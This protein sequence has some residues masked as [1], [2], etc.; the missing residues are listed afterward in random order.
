MPRLQYKLTPE[1]RAIVVDYIDRKFASDLAA[2]PEQRW[3][4]NVQA[5][6][7]FKQAKRNVGTLDAWC[8]LWLDVKQRRRLK[9]SLRQAKKRKAANTG[10]NE[11]YSNI[12]LSRRA[13]R[14]LSGLAKHHGVTMSA[15]IE[16]R[17]KREWLDLD[18]E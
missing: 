13:W 5:K 1:D 15:F 11:G 18:I 10:D 4:D 12:T 2:K 8:Q 17:H 7:K 3:P 9:N 14:I 6:N 16:K